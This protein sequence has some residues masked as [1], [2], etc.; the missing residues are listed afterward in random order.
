MLLFRSDYYYYS[1][2]DVDVVGVEIDE[3]FFKD[4]GLKVYLKLHYFCRK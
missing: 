4:I 2:G 3:I 1:S